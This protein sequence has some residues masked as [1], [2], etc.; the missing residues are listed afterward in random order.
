[1]F[2]KILLIL[3][4][5]IWPT[6][7]F[8]FTINCYGG[9][10]STVTLP[11]SASLDKITVGL[12][13]DT[14][15]YRKLY[16][17]N[18]FHFGKAN[19]QCQVTESGAGTTLLWVAFVRTSTT[20]HIHDGNIIFPTSI[21]GIGISFNEMTS[22]GNK[23][24]NTITTPTVLGSWSLTNTLAQ[25]TPEFNL[26]ITLWKIPGKLGTG[27]LN[28][29]DIYVDLG[30]QAKASDSYASR[31]NMSSS[32]ALDTWSV[33]HAKLSGT[34]DIN[35]GTCDIENK[36][37]LMGEHFGDFPSR[38][39]DAT[40]TV[41]CPTSWGY[42]MTATLNNSNVI[43]SRTA[44]TPHMGLALSVLPRAGIVSAIPGT[45]ALTPGGATGYGIQLVWGDANTLTSSTGIP[46]DTVIFDAPNVVSTQTFTPGV[47]PAPVQVKLAA[48][49][50][51]TGETKSPGLANSAIE[52]LAN[53]N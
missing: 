18:Y 4:V 47:T 26:K 14:T 7:S 5:V 19:S 49:Y 46:S 51:P 45:I 52:I 50:V 40:F 21:N 24:L 34:L 22:G 32:A 33:M 16:T 23:A 41:N 20:P 10:E 43:S 27:S 3:T 38:W 28:F 13:N 25:A 2:K 35:P 36:T 44:N 9:S 17:Y 39:K 11:H 15:H 30:L 48:R 53:Y 8:A 31:M 29:S 12:S 1:M 42:G 6:L 37:V